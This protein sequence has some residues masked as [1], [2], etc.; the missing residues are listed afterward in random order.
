MERTVNHRGYVKRVKVAGPP[1]FGHGLSAEPPGRPCCL[2]CAHMT[3][4]RLLGGA[5]RLCRCDKSP[6]FMRA[7]SPRHT[8]TCWVRWRPK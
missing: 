4:S 5:K 2:N 6:Y 3:A 7:M 1:P 8:C